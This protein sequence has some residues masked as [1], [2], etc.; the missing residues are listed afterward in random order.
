VIHVR[1]YLK[2]G[3]VAEFDATAITESGG[4]HPTFRLEFSPPIGAEPGI[5]RLVYL[6]RDDVSAVVVEERGGPAEDAL[7]AAVSAPVEV[8]DTIR[9]EVKEM[10]EGAAGA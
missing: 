5:R 4:P 10:L 8:P 3:A 6:D 9:Q 7:R 1:V 2:S